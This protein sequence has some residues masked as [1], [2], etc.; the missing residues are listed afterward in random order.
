[1]GLMGWMGLYG[2][3]GI[4]GI[5]G[6]E[7]MDGVDGIFMHMGLGGWVLGVR[8]LNWDLLYLSLFK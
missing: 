7:Q 2:M 6:M 8:L 3:D 5:D 1:M 4:D